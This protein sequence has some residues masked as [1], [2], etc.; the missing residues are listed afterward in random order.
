MSSQSH[1]RVL[2]IQGQDHSL[3]IIQSTIPI[4][5]DSPEVQQEVFIKSRRPIPEVIPEAIQAA[6]IITQVTVRP[7]QNRKLRPIQ[8][9]PVIRIQLRNRLD[10]LP[11]T[12]SHTENMGQQH[13]LIHS[14]G[15]W[16]TGLIWYF[17]SRAR[18]LKGAASGEIFNIKINRNRQSSSTS[19]RA[20]S[21]KSY[22][23]SAYGTAGYSSGHQRSSSFTSTSSYGSMSRLNLLKC[24]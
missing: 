20:S 4:R 9:Y 11:E 8:V 13:K 16:L 21:G 1:W 3:G 17:C 23:S 19:H 7:I 14:I 2:R 22:G 15:T 18:V 5:P 12:N 6:R 24:Y 10:V